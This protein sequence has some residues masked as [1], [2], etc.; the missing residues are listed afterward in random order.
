MI[1]AEP[2]NIQVSAEIPAAPV[3]VNGDEQALARL[4]LILLDNAVKYSNEGG[5]VTFAIRSSDS[6]AE[7]LVSDTGIGIAA[8]DLP[9]IFDRFWRADKVRSR[10]S[11][12][13]GL[14]LSIARWIVQ[15][16]AGE[17]E[18]AS[19]PGQGSQ[20]VVRLPHPNRTATVRERLTA[21]TNSESAADPSSAR[22]LSLPS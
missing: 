16:H 11:G 20:V 6:H 8:M 19:E 17:I 15:R 10:A 7:V 1:L 22:P 18:I 21:P 3:F 2:K 5:H 9:R 12:G 14:G 13:A 4:C